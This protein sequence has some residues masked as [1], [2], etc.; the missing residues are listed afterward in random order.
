MHYAACLAALHRLL[1]QI[2]FIKLRLAFPPLFVWNRCSSKDAL[3]H[4][5]VELQQIEERERKAL[6]KMVWGMNI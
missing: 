5:C 2:Q 6:R 3:C 1:M 4:T